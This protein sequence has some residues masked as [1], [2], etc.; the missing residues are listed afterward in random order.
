MNGHENERV[1]RMR[2]MMMAAL[3][4]ELSV[5]QR[6]E[7]EELLAGDPE[8]RK[9]WERLNGVKEVTHA[10]VFRRPPEEIWDQYFE[11]TYNRLERGMAWVLLS[12]GTLIVVGYALWHALNAILAATDLPGYLKFGIFAALFGGA[13]L[14]V[15]VIRERLFVRKTDPYREIER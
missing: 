10:M 13:I 15:S 9:E 2:R 6:T 7:F 11:S 3:D 4:D 1:E 12:L 8:L 14:L 5:E